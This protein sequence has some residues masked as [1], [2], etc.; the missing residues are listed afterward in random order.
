MLRV[1]IG[2]RYISKLENDGEY[3]EIFWNPPEKYVF[4]HFHPHKPRVFKIYRAEISKCGPEKRPYS[5]AE[6]AQTELN[7]IKELG[8]NAVLLGGIQ[9]H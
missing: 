7:R 6:F 3:C 1:P 5:Y 2:A 9:E 4:Q 8:Y